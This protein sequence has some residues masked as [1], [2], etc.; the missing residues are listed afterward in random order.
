MFSATTIQNKFAG[1]V[2]FRQTM[3]AGFDKLDADIVAS[4]SGILIDQSSGHPLITAE[5]IISCAEVYKKESVR[6]WDAEIEYAVG[7]VV[8]LSSTMY[9]CIQAGANQYPNEA[10]TYWTETNL[11]SAYLRSVQQS[12]AINVFNA[13][14]AKRKLHEVAKTLL[15]DTSLYDGTGSLTNKITK[16]GRFVG[17]RIKPKYRDTVL[18][19]SAAGFQ[20]DTANPDF[21]L[22]VYQSSSLEPLNEI[23][24]AHNKVVTFEW[25]QLGTEIK[26]RFNAE[27][28]NDNCYYYIGYYESDLAGQAIWKENVLFENGCSSCN[29]VNSLLYQRWSN[30]F[31]IQPIYVAST[32]V[33]QDKTMFEEDK[34]ILLA[35]QN[36]GMNF[37]FQVHC[38]VTDMI[39]RNKNAFIDAIRLQLIH[40]ILNSMAFSM[41]DNQLKQKVSQMAFYALENK[42]NYEKGIRSQ[43]DKAIDG[44]SF[45]LSDINKICLPCAKA[46]SGVKIK[47]VFNR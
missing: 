6:N 22:Y 36:W 26:L 41:R 4:S 13:V 17:Y 40:D 2:G 34:Q 33:K 23:D 14:F 32:F 16:L 21:K 15:T 45:D 20:F 46:A 1:L 35:N 5:N 10:P 44:V 24:I 43:L 9:R 11:L 3:Q 30:F 39:C 8:V 42:D 18:I 28:L 47:S 38:D 25:H 29:S 12:A 27:S 31:E 7:D 19:I 37:R